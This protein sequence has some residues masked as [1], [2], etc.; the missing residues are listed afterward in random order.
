M[1]ISTA[2]AGKVIAFEGLDGAGKSTVIPLLRRHL[3][4]AGHSGFLPRTGG[5]HSSQPTRMVRD[6]TRDRTDIELRPR[7]EMALYCAREAQVLD[8]QVGGGDGPGGDLRLHPAHA[9]AARD[10]RGQ[11][12]LVRRRR[13]QGQ[14]RDPWQRDHRSAG[15]VLDPVS[16][17]PPIT[18]PT[19]PL[20]SPSRGVR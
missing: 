5:E 17:A 12:L 14:A 11:A 4:Q 9:G 6:L 8:E 18:G 1:K 16:H 15:R 7:T 13:G 20:R 2:L 3:R 10:R 19:A